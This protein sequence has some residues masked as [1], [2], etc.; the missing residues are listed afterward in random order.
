MKKAIII[1]GVEWSC[2]ELKNWLC[3]EFGFYFGGR[4]SKTSVKIH[5]LFLTRD[6]LTAIKFSVKTPKSMQ[7][8]GYRTIY[9][10]CIFETGIFT[11]EE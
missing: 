7:Y 8:G 11:R 4:I 2:D 9:Y 1:K 6:D 5:F 3:N 10:T